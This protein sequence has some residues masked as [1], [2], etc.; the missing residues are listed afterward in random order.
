MSSAA[1]VELERRSFWQRPRLALAAVA[2]VVAGVSVYLGVFGWSGG[3]QQQAAGLSTATVVAV[4]AA[5]SSIRATS[6]D[7]AASTKETT[8]PLA[9]ARAVRPERCR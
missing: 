8:V 5:A 3:T 9:P 4:T 2:L 7:C 6:R 1:E